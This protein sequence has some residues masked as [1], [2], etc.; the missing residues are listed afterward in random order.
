MTVSRTIPFLGSEAEPHRPAGNGGTGGGLVAARQLEIVGK[1]GIRR[2]HRDD[3]PPIPDADL[4]IDALA[5]CSL[6]GAPRGTT[7]RVIRLANES[8]APILS[9]DVPSGLDA[10]TGARE[11]PTVRA[12]A[13]VTLALP[14]SGLRSPADHVGELYLADIGVPPSL[15]AQPRLG[16]PV[17]PLFAR[18]AIL[19]LRPPRDRV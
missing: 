9:L 11:D 14:K 5:G 2:D 18:Q 19:R 7:A 15:Y 13:T 4:I 1:P 10:A 8:S 3:Q 16:L 17:G 6:R 12:D